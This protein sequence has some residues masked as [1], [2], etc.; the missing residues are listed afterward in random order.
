MLLVKTKIGK[1]DIHGTG[2]FA[3]EF[4]PKG[5][6]TWEWNP[7]IDIAFDKSVVESLPDIQKDY[8]LYYAYLDKDLNKLVLC[9]DNQRY[10][11]HSKKTNV[12]STPRKD[13][14][15]KDIFPGDELLCDDKLFDNTYFQRLNIDEEKLNS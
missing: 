14:A 11:N 2:L 8:L 10:I 5:T 15:N 9:S 4:I 7:L 3:D 1:S 12:D 13:V 6:V